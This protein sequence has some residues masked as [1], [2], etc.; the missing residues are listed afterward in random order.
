MTTAS[1]LPA[2][3]TEPGVEML[4]H[5][6]AAPSPT[7]LAFGALL[8][9]LLAPGQPAPVTPVAPTASDGDV[10]PALRDAEPQAADSASGPLVAAQAPLAAIVM[11]MALVPPPV[12]AS[13]PQSPA[14]PSGTGSVGG[15]VPGP[16]PAPVSPSSVTAT[17]SMSEIGG[18]PAG[19]AGGQAGWP[20]AASEAALRHDGGDAPASIP[21]T[22]DVPSA[23]MPDGGVATGDA[24]A[25]AGPGA[26]ET[27]LE[28]PA[29]A[30]PDARGAAT[31]TRASSP[32]APADLRSV[33]EARPNDH[34][35]AAPAPAPPA[36]VATGD[37]PA[38]AV[39]GAQA[40]ALPEAR[41][42]VGSPRDAR[43]APDV[44]VADALVSP[45][46]A[47]PGSGASTGAGARDRDQ[48]PRSDATSDIVTDAAGASAAPRPAGTPEATP[49]SGSAAGA[50]PVVQQLAA[51]IGRLRR[52]GRQ[53]VSLRLDPPHL[54]A[55]RI[56]ARLDGSQLML[57]IH[58]SVP[59]TRDLLEQGLPRL[60]EALAQQG[61]VPGQVTIGL[62][63][64]GSSR[65]SAGDAF[66]PPPPA[67]APA[68]PTR[69]ETAARARWHD[70][71]HDGFEFWV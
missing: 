3:S 31:V 41:E 45:T 64:D 42:P 50:P 58:A 13:T 65:R 9:R 44:V 34:V 7:D 18:S 15:P 23:A 68:A 33:A 67:P 48:R 43:P 40:R 30:A 71:G 51:G 22:A 20:T 24:P 37:L 55:V 14:L 8:A 70:A 63:L 49:V 62:G 16:A 60:R 28:A 69:T 52:E 25:L 6:Q 26:T 47:Q 4:D 57:Q 39:P 38:G 27:I 19:P 11:A 53:E 21:S 36:R 56:E 10:A 5:G 35:V 66:A 46:A 29:P 32:P 2:I 12:P 61:I 59:A 17:G 54:G 1:A